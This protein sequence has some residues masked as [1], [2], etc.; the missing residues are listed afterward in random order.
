[1]GDLSP[2]STPFITALQVSGGN[3]THINVPDNDSVLHVEYMAHHVDT[4]PLFNVGL[5][6]AP[7][8]KKKKV[9][10]KVCMPTFHL[11]YLL[12]LARWKAL[13]L[14]LLFYI[15]CLLNLVGVG[16]VELS[17]KRKAILDEGSDSVD[18]SRVETKKHKV[19][20]QD[21]EMV[22]VAEVGL[23]QPREEQ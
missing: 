15:I 6:P 1:M 16:G 11:L 20:L 22:Q 3:P 12:G 19:T 10:K 4:V 18:G 2:I 14:V 13:F 5:A 7:L 17:G 23:N 21:H 8:K 9:G